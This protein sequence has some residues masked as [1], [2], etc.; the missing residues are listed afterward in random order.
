MSRTPPITRGISHAKFGDIK[1]GGGPVIGRRGPTSTRGVRAPRPSR[2]DGGRPVSDRGPLPGHSGTDAWPI[3]VS[4]AGI[5]TGLVSVPL[6]YM[7]TPTEVI[8]L[9][10]LDAT[11][12]LFVQFARD[13]ESGGS[14]VPMAGCG[15]ASLDACSARAAQGE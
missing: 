13:L 8:C 3:Q 5:P 9:D 7:H 6:R 14:F 15:S 1:C 10:D 2:Q 12:A 4:R 11:V